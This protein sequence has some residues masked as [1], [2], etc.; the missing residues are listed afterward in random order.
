M[1]T[2]KCAG[3]RVLANGVCRQCCLSAKFTY[4]G[5]C[6]SS[7]MEEAR[8][9]APQAIDD[10]I[11]NFWKAVEKP[12]LTAKY[13]NEVRKVFFQ[14]IS[15]A[16]AKEETEYGLNASASLGH[17][18]STV[19]QEAQATYDSAQAVAV[20]QHVQNINANRTGFKRRQ[21]TSCVFDKLAESDEP[22]GTQKPGKRGKRS[23]TGCVFVDDEAHEEG[24][25]GFC[26]V[27]DVSEDDVARANAEVEHA[28][29]Q[30]LPDDDDDEMEWDEIL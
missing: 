9:Y 4:K 5:F 24:H 30:P 3:A 14:V 21:L 28:A 20:N 13:N 1:V 12:R 7:H 15:G 18:A 23:N 16:M 22:V 2:V 26:F 6:S 11:A 29:Q 27:G 19:W 25:D 17:H 10:L 8:Q